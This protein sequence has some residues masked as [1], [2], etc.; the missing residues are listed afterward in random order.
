MLWRSSLPRACASSQSWTMNFYK[1]YE[2]WSPCHFPF[3][4]AF[5]IVIVSTSS[6]GKTI[7]RRSWNLTYARPEPNSSSPSPPSPFTSIF[8]FRSNKKY[9]QQP[10]CSYPNPSGHHATSHNFIL[11][12]W[13]PMSP[14]IS[15]HHRY[16]LKRTTHL[17]VTMTSRALSSDIAKIAIA[18][19]LNSQ[20]SITKLTCYGVTLNTHVS[21]DIR[22]LCIFAIRLIWK[23]RCINIFHQKL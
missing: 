4:H 9:Q 11:F 2:S 5:V 22:I 1:K 17:A 20:Q 23:E 3:S 15:R 6:L 16:Q 12:E 13:T 19:T 7:R 8:L 14:S 10:W 21:E 18:T